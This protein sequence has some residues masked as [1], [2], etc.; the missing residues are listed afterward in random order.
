MK[1]LIVESPGKIKKLQEFLGAD[2][3][4]AASFGHIRDLPEKGNYGLE[5]P[6]FTPI[7][8][9]TEKGVSAVKKLK[10]LAAQADE[11][12]LASD[13]DREGE[14]I[15]WHLKEVLGLTSYKR[16]TF[17]SI[18]KEAVEAAVASPRKIDMPLV[19]AQ[20]ARRA[21]DRL[22]GY[23]I[24]LA[25]ALGE[26]GLSCGRVQSPTVRLVVDNDREI[27]AFVSTTHY[28][29]ELIFEQVENISEGWQAVWL[30][31]EGW[32]EEG[33]E[34]VL[35]QAIAEK[36]SA[37]RTLEV[38]AFEDK[39]S[40]AAPPA[41]FITSTLQQVANKALKFKAKRTME[42]AQKLYEGG[43]ITYM[44]TD[45]PNLSASAIAEIRAYA[46]AQGLPLPDKGRTW[47]SKDGAQEAHEAIRPTHIENED[48]TLDG[49]SLGVPDKDKAAFIK[50]AS[51]LYKLIRLRALASQ[52]ADAVFAVRVARLGASVDGKQAIFEARGR[53]LLEKGWKQVMDADSE[54]SD[55]S[56]AS[57]AVPELKP[58][59]SVVAL[60]GK[61]STKK[62]KPKARYTEATLI[63]DLEKR[64]IGRP[65]TYATILTNIMGR[66]YL[67][68]GE[69]GYLFP[70]ATGE[71]LVDALVSSFK[72][73]DLEFTKGM[74]DALDEVASGKM[75]YE[76]CMITMHNSLMGELSDF[77]KKYLVPCPECGNQDDFILWNNKEKGWNHWHCKACGASFANDQ[78]RPGKKREKPVL[79]DFSCEKC[80]QPLKHMKGDKGKNGLPYDFFACSSK[81]CGASY[82]NV[83]GKPVARKPKELSEFKCKKCGKPLTLR[84]WPRKSDGKLCRKFECSDWKNCKIGYWV[85]D[86]GTPNYDKPLEK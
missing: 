52:L 73:M 85:K 46:D 68:E 30:P 41:P 12:Y 38:L 13:P 75:S 8:E 76:T 44:R 74:E 14:A 7:Y 77:K 42:L 37:A 18:T 31:K 22:V 51:A 69:K 25:K 72:F 21:L 15:S 26:A 9:I 47:K 78:G 2:W 53:T 3:R 28:G 35:D 27:K 62:T 20:E 64:G 79:T 33:Q 65:A 82:D 71:K 23:S 4:V 11:V 70:S 61:V 67:K 43:H 36:V 66:Q 40:R 10:E 81:D 80:G 54:E 17:N 48:V 63:R 34:Y 32:L 19:Y 49:D 86:D 50:D 57:N 5:P 16:V 59:A 83:D 1:L 55:D 39:E 45:C 60:Q 58:G 84:E 56:G 24:P 6:N 29:A